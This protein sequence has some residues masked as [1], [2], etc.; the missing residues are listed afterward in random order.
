MVH[1]DIV[2][3]STTLL[4]LYERLGCQF[5]DDFHTPEED[6]SDPTQIEN[7]NRDL[8]KDLS[9]TVTLQRQR[10]S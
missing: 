9:Y 2:S 6:W 8:V 10:A 3:M 1:D 5:E 4:W 7:D